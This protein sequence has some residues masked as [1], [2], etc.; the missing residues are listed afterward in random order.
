VVYLLY[1]LT[2]IAAQTLTSR[3]FVAAGNAVNVVAYAL[4][5]LLALLFYYMFKPVSNGLSLLAALVSLAG[6][7]E[8]ILDV[9][10]RAPT[11][12]SPLWFFSFFGIL[13]EAMLMLWLIIK[14]VN[15][16]L[17]R[18]RAPQRCQDSRKYR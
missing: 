4:Y 14:G 5:I 12:L 3:N 18:R 17:W 8:G 9:F 15:F 13:A 7:F 10:H 2:A 6:S 1:F 11:K 16:E